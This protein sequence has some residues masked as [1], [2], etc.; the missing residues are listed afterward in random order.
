MF[1]PITLREALNFLSLHKHTH[2]FLLSPPQALPQWHLETP[3]QADW[4]GLDFPKKHATRKSLII[5]QIVFD[6]CIFASHCNTV[7]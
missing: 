7:I 2:T 3:W 6:F 4:R 1:A 5:T